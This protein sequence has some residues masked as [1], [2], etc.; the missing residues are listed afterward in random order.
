MSYRL[1]V[2]VGGTFIGSAVD[3]RIDQQVIFEVKT[4]STPGD[5][6]EGC[7]DRRGQNLPDRR[8]LARQAPRSLMHGTTVATN[9]VLEG[10]A[11]RSA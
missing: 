5:Q 10:K 9:A 8:D 4:P 7:A 6:S 1:G 2:D 3:R 11:R